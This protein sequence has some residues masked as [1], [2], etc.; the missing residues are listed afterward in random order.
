MPQ[1]KFITRRQAGIREGRVNFM[2][3][4]DDP[5][6]TA[7]TPS[8]QIVNVTKYNK[9][10]QLEEPIRR[11]HRGQ[12]TDAYRA[13]MKAIEPQKDALRIKANNDRRIAM[14]DDVTSRDAANARVARQRLA[15]RASASKAQPR[16][17][18][19]LANPML[20][21][22]AGIAEAD[23]ATDYKRVKYSGNFGGPSFSV[24]PYASSNKSAYNGQSNIS[25]LM[26]VGRKK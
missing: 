17:G 2:M 6:N 9:T 22:A 3:G 15:T 4:G 8:E 10:R 18:G 12:F 13:D 1:D 26:G 19:I 25:K 11:K 21:V 16:G 14:N 20:G 23:K 7:S 5:A 24:N